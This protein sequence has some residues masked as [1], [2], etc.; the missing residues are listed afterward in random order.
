M[1]AESTTSPTHRSK[2]TAGSEGCGGY[3][4]SRGSSLARFE[5]RLTGSSPETAIAGSAKR[6][7][8]AFPPQK[9]EPDSSSDRLDSALKTQT[10]AKRLVVVRWFVRGLA[11]G[12]KDACVRKNSD[13][14]LELI[15]TDYS[16]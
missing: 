5:I 2:S 16:A 12:S 4:A 8:A 9:K 14:I 11:L 7:P 13:H 15:R 6:K 1:N 10:P 3:R